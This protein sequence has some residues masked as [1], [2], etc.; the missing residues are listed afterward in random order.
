MKEIRIRGEGGQIAVQVLG[1]ERPAAGNL[2]D[3]NWLNCS[4]NVD[5]SPFS[6]HYGA[7]LSTQDFLA[8]GEELAV[9]SDRLAG[10]AKFDTDEG[11]L[12]LRLVMEPLGELLIEGEAVVVGAIRA[13]LKFT[14]HA[15]QSYLGELRREVAAALNEF[16]VR[17]A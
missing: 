14:L 16:P 10:E 7:S 11:A 3:A 13:A 1:Y 8:F 17:V 5:I 9:M 4:I 15:D 6:G 2:S 12:S